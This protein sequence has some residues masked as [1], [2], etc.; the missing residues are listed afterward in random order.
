MSWNDLSM[1]DRA[2]Y[3]KLGLDS[4]ITNLKVV[5]DTYNKYAEGG[6]IKSDDYYDYME[7]LAAKKAKDWNEDPDI[8]LMHMLNDNTYNYREFYEKEP[9]MAMKML[10]ADPNAHFTDIGKT[11]YH[12]TFS[13]ESSYSGKKSDY[14]PRGTVGGSWKGDNVYIPSRS[15]YENGDFNYKRTRNY[16]D[17]DSS[18]V[19]IDTRNKY[20]TGGEVDNDNEGIEY[21]VNLGYQLSNLLVA[22]INRK[23][24]R[25]AHEERK[26]K[27][28]EIGS[29][30]NYGWN[31]S[32]DTE[33]KG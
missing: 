22:S 28:V 17:I 16:L 13:N 9:Q 29:T 30:S 14:N 2:A 7:K 31:N 15:Q 24:D 11:V 6:N 19:R 20:A 26:S 18:N 4:G 27:D 10:T 5:R 1:A 8:I 32:T 23:K 12:P 25:E 3:I 33:D 21:G